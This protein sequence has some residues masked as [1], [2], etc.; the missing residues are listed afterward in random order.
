MVFLNKKLQSCETVDNAIR[1]SSELIM[2]YSEKNLSQS[3]IERSDRI[4]DAFDQLSESNEPRPDMNKM[5]ES[6]IF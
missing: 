5:S 2:K 1:R 6:F 3:A 4:K